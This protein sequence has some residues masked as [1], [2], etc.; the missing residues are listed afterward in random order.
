MRRRQFSEIIRILQ[1]SL[2]SRN[3][4]PPPSARA[5]TAVG[6]GGERKMETAV[7]VSFMIEFREIRFL[8]FLLQH[9][10]F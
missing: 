8:I 5:S 4:S 9:W 3:L 2:R 6:G 10:A 1:K 7:A